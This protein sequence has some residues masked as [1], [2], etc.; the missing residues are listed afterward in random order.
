MNQVNIANNVK[1]TNT[2]NNLIKKINQNHNMPKNIL[3]NEV[4]NKRMQSNSRD[5]TYFLKNIE[6]I[7]KR[8]ESIDI[9][10]SDVKSVVKTLMSIIRYIS[11]VFEDDSEVKKQT[12]RKLLD[13][14]KNNKEFIKSLEE[15]LN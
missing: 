3:E 15:I 11:D 2:Q 5:V 13:R 8:I 7:N 4:K 1:L 12:L 10:K 6:K 14:V 9:D